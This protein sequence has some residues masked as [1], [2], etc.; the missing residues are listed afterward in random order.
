MVQYL[1]GVAG[2]A[3]FGSGATAEQVATK[4]ADSV[5]GK[6]VIV[7]GAT[8]GFGKETARV[9]AAKG[10]HVY[11]C[12]RTQA[13]G[14]AVVA[15]IKKE[16][17]AAQLAVIEIDLESLES[18]RKAAAEFKK[19]KKPIDVLINNAGVMNSPD[20]LRTKDGLEYQ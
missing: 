14:D 3:G 5:Q 4:Y 9:L 19:L 20:E 11:V 7:T 17:P 8:S 12:A 15:E 18:V 1:T 13:K 6:T 2:P 10:A 16:T